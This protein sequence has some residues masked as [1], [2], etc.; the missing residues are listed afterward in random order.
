MD[1]GKGKERK[2]DVSLSFCFNN[3]GLRGP[4]FIWSLQINSI[5]KMSNNCQIKNSDNK[6]VGVY[7]SIPIKKGEIAY[8]CEIETADLPNSVYASQVA[9][10]KW[11]LFTLIG[12][13]V[14]HSCD[15]NCGVTF[16]GANWHF[17]AMRDIKEGEE[18]TYDY[19]MMNYVVENFPRCL[20]QSS[21]CR[22]EVKG[23][24]ILPEERRKEYKGYLAPYLEKLM[25]EESK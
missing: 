21:K 3:Y 4:L 19:D 16:D 10:D 6:G 14:N 20:C 7:T 25:A 5:I 18:I 11:I 15:P 17:V 24:K 22:G 8:T 2:F 1:R 12:R 13:S 9:M 23:F